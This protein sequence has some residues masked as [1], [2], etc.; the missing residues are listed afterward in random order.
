VDGNAACCVVKCVQF[1]TVITKEGGYYVALCPELDIASQGKSVEQALRNLREAIL[2]YLEDED[3]EVPRQEFKPL[4]TLVEVDR[5]E[6]SH[7]V[8]ATDD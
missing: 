7:S 2:L 8:R 3:A 6:A 4:V 5:V 1:S